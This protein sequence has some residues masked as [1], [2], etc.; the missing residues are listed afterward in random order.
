MTFGWAQAVACLLILLF[1]T[2][3]IFG[4]QRVARLQNVLTGTKVLILVS[5]IVLAFTVG[6]GDWHHFSMN[7]TRTSTNSIPAQF[8][9][10]L[11]FIYVA[12]SGWNAATYVAEELKQP[13]RTLPLALTV[14][15]LL[16]AALSM[17][18]FGTSSS[19]TP[20]RSKT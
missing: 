15:T 9:V 1:T 18:D 14:G 4:V 16:V 2:V 6:N 17:S 7:A 20:R 5:F 13:S 11:F 8:V 12:Y 3:N 19:F 10:S